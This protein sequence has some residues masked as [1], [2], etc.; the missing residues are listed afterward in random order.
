M[1]H[2]RH[3]AYAVL[4]IL[5]T[6][7][8][9]PRGTSA[10]AVS[11]FAQGMFSATDIRTQT[12]AWFQSK[13]AERIKL[14]N[15]PIKQYMDGMIAGTTNDAIHIDGVRITG[16]RDYL[17]RNRSR[18]AA[19]YAGH[20]TIGAYLKA[21]KFDA[22]NLAYFDAMLGSLNG[23]QMQKVMVSETKAMQKSAALGLDDATADDSGTVASGFEASATGTSVHGSFPTPAAPGPASSLPAGA[24]SSPNAPDSSTCDRINKADLG[25]TIAGLVP[26][27]GA[28]ANLGSHLNDI[29][30]LSA[31][32]TGGPGMCDILVDCSKPMNEMSPIEISAATST[33]YS[34]PAAGMI[35]DLRLKDI[36]GDFNTGLDAVRKLHTVRFKYKKDNPLQLPSTPEHTGFIAQ[37]LRKVIPDAVIQRKDG[38]FEVNFLPVHWATVNAIKELAADNDRLHAESA[39]AKA[40]A[41]RSDAEVAKLKGESALLKALVCSKFP[42]EKACQD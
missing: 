22:K 31:N 37:E 12:I 30:A 42:G 27:V 32:C 10:S 41:D 39:A 38:F 2:A 5:L 26:Y 8:A 6:S 17:E 35:S 7:C 11:A 3:F 40:R 13:Q 1:Q 19:K 9:D 16:L 24:R 36:T 18:I 20:A 14:E 33:L 25:L 34:V 21:K 28:A 4:A 15:M 29:A 23:Q